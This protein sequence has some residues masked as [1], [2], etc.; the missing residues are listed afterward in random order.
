MVPVEIVGILLVTALV[1]L[2][3]SLSVT[4]GMYD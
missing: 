1:T 4:E 3:I 2:I